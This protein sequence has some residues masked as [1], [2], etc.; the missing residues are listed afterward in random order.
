MEGSVRHISFLR[1]AAAFLLLASLALALPAAAAPAPLTVL[2]AASLH[3]ALDAAVKQWNKSSDV[4]I[5]VSYAGT[6][7]L[8][9]QIEAGAPADVFISADLDWMDREAKKNLIV[10]DT[11]QDLLGNSLVLVA[12][13]D[14]SKGPVAISAKTDFKNLIGSGKLAM[15]MVDSVPAGKYGKQALTAL[16]QWDKVQPSVVQA[17]NVRVAL[18]YVARGEAQFGIVYSTDAA[19]EPKVKV[20][21]TFPASSHPA[22]IYPIAVLKTS[23]NPKTATDFVHFLEGS[24]AQKVFM[25]YGFVKPSAARNS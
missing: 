4:P 8:A 11:R 20:V 25:H 17:E 12:P 19:I 10:A 3:D 22:I 6:S 18:A 23:A 9:K 24:D 7:A 5:R 14:W 1:L 2:A 15:A 16:G 13:A 21:G